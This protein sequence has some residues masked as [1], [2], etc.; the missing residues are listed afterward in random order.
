MIALAAGVAIVAGA[1]VSPM[2]LTEQSNGSRVAI[3]AGETL[4]VQLP[5]QMGTGYGWQVQG[6]ELTRATQPGAAQ[7]QVF[8]ILAVAPGHARLRFEYRQPWDHQT[9][10]RKIFEVTVNIDH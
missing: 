10:P 3:H 1:S 2:Q 9:P 4:I 7:L 6:Q 5:A 8:H